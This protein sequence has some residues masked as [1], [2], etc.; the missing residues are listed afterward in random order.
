MLI[1]AYFGFLILAG[2]GLLS[3]ALLQSSDFPAPGFLLSALSFFC[4][5]AVRVF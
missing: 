1:P 5:C 2:F 3:A 4:F